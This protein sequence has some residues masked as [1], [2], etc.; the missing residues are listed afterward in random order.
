MYA[1]T[2]L[3]LSGVCVCCF[4]SS[5]VKYYD[6]PE[7]ADNVYDMLAHIAKTHNY[8]IKKRNPAGGCGHMVGCV[9]I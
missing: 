7:A 6:M 1:H 3:A 9:H 4:T 2:D 5:Y 8:V